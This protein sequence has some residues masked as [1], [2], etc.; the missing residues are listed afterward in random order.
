[1]GKT[2][3]LITK[4][5]EKKHNPEIDKFIQENSTLFWWIKPEEKVNISI[6]A[7]V[8]SVLNYGNVKSI[9]RLFDLVEIT[10]VADM[11]NKQISSKRSNYHKRT[12]HFFQ[13]YFKRHAYRNINK[14]TK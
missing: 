12:K 5:N 11:F 7:L 14:G 2:N 4:K 1:M 9:K 10:K 6:E 3:S 13:I 8:E